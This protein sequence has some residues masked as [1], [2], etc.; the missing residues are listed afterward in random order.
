MT[1][2]AGN[3]I[4]A[5]TAGSGSA[6]SANVRY[7]ILEPIGRRTVELSI[8]QRF[9]VL[10]NIFKHQF[11]ATY[12]RIGERFGWDVANE[13]AGDVAADATPMLAA[14]YQRKFALPGKGAALVSQVVQAEFQAEGSDAD[15]IREDGDEAELDIL[16]GFGS[17]LQ[18]PKFQSI[19]ITSGL[20][21][22]G[23]RLWIDEIA[24]TVEPDLRAERLT[25][26]GAGAARCRFRIRRETANS[27][28]PTDR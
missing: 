27:E 4:P 2:E 9:G 23:C 26:M 8:E 17:A 22:T 3:H 1:D 11:F 6:P 7:P 10:H 28:S 14:A 21:E 12:K 20:C 15:V 16:C 5:D 13:I 24:Q 18:Q 19:E 25:W